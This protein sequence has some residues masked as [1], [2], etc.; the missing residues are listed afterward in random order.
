VIEIKVFFLP[1]NS[2]KNKNTKKFFTAMIFLLLLSCQKEESK[3]AYERKHNKTIENKEISLQWNEQEK[4]FFKLNATVQNRTRNPNNIYN[5][6]L[7]M[8]IIF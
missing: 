4:K 7:W 1:L 6:L 5:P 3:Q 2:Y 8:F